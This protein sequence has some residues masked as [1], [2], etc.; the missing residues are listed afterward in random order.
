MQHSSRPM[1]AALRNKAAVGSCVL[2]VMLTAVI[3]LLSSQA[4]ARSIDLVDTGKHFEAV[5]HS[6]AYPGL[7]LKRTAP[8]PNAFASQSLWGWD[9]EMEM[10][11]SGTNHGYFFPTNTAL[12]NYHPH[13]GPSVWFNINQTATSPGEGKYSY[14]HCP[15]ATSQTCDLVNRQDDTRIT[16]SALTTHT[17]T[18]LNTW[19][20]IRSKQFRDGTTIFYDFDSNAKCSHLTIRHGPSGQGYRVL[21]RQLYDSGSGVAYCAPETVTFNGDV[22]TYAWTVVRFGTGAHDIAGPRLDSVTYPDGTK[23]N[24]EYSFVYRPLTLQQRQQSTDPRDHIF[25]TKVTDEEGKVYQTVG[26]DTSRRP[27]SAHYGSSAEQHDKISVTYNSTGTQRT[28][29]DADGIS[30]TFNY[31]KVAGA[32]RLTGVSGP[33]CEWCPE[34]YQSIT[35][36]SHGK[37]TRLVDHRGTVTTITY[38]GAED[39]LRRERQRVVGDGMPE[40]TTVTTT[41]HPTFNLPTQVVTSNA[42]GTFTEKTAYDHKGRTTEQEFIQ[43]IAL[44]NGSNRTV[45]RKIT[46]SYTDWPNG[47][48]QTVVVTGP[49]ANNVTTTQFDTAG[50]LLSTSNALNQTTHILEHD[51]HGRPTRIRASNGVE[52]LRTYDKRGRLLSESI[53][54]VEQRFTYYANGLLKTKTTPGVA[55]AVLTYTYDDA[56]RLTGIRNHLGE[57]VVYAYDSLGRRT[58]TDVLNAWGSRVAIEQTQ[59][60][61]GG[62]TV[63]SYVG[64]QSG[65]STQANMDAG[66]LPS[67]LVDLPRHWTFTHDS[68]GRQIRSREQQG[69][70]VERQFDVAG[71]LKSI[72]HTG[73]GASGEVQNLLFDYAADAKGDV[74]G[75]STSTTGIDTLEH[76][77]AGNVV[78][79]SNSLGGP[80]WTTEY[81]ALNR[82]FRSRILHPSTGAVLGTVN[83]QYD[84]AHNG[85]VAPHGQLTEVSGTYGTVRFEY[86]RKGF[87]TRKTQTRP[88]TSTPTTDAYEYDAAGRLTMMTYPSGRQVLYSL[89]SVGRPQA[90]LTRST[91]S[92]EWILV[93]SGISYTAT[94]MVSR[95]IPVAGGSPPQGIYQNVYYDH[96]GRVT[97]YH[98]GERTIDVT[99]HPDGRV[100]GL[101]SQFVGELA[102]YSYDRLGRIASASGHFGVGQSRTLTYSFNNM[103]NLRSMTDAG[104]STS[105]SYAPGSSRL[106]SVGG[107]A[108]SYV[109]RGLVSRDGINDFG[110]D[111]RGHLTTAQT[112][113]GLA[114]YKYDYEGKRTEKRS[115]DDAHTLFHYDAGGRLIAENLALP[116]G[117]SWIREYVWLGPRPLM[118]IVRPGQGGS[119]LRYNIHVDHTDTP[120]RVTAPDRSTV[121][122]WLRD[123]FGAAV[124]HVAPPFNLPAYAFNLRMPGQY[125]DAETGYHYNWKR[126]YD[127]RTGRYLQPDPLGEPAGA[128]L[129]TYAHGDPVRFT[130]PLGLAPMNLGTMTVYGTP[131]N[132]NVGSLG[133]TGGGYSGGGGFGYRP[134]P[135]APLKTQSLACG[136][137]DA[138]GDYLNQMLD[139][140]RDVLSLPQV[141]VVFAPGLGQIGRPIMAVGAKAAA[142]NMGAGILMGTTFNI[143]SDMFAGRTNPSWGAMGS[144]AGTGAFVGYLAPVVPGGPVG[145]AMFRG[146]T[147]FTSS[148]GTQY[149]LSGRADFGVAASTAFAGGLLGNAGPFAKHV[150]WPLATTTDKYLAAVPWAVPGMAL[151]GEAKS[152]AD[153]CKGGS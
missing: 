143:A 71:G 47:Q 134:P 84:T 91:A 75:E 133:V 124:P 25:L 56:R 49:R 104:V 105:L 27:F 30:R 57:R 115:P 24:Y 72:E 35:Y 59:F 14:V 52:T 121:W 69:Y 127:P 29:T 68:Q 70:T 32:L 6:T 149:A 38:Y 34:P 62:Q 39:P 122:S 45:N 13:E 132:Q 97:Q 86:D 41:W 78:A 131:G 114:D 3:G 36:N 64:G 112:P 22:V 107:R 100:S 54:G 106:T 81:D 128:A 11:R 19:Y 99:Y 66:F 48:T 117:T 110:Y 137:R 147:W 90:V 148:A 76:D 119:E 21:R 61:S 20:R 33:P 118:F 88:G 83:L 93:A 153:G 74:W 102:S 58:L 145:Q 146:A 26:Y 53:D 10:G 55:S 17:T 116:N 152:R 120:V 4:H 135:R 129:Y 130:D 85:G 108:Y 16:F 139:L 111:K 95:I 92:Q 113:S 125:F 79:G 8:K 46:T 23:T 12:V 151:V 18:K 1:A 43:T 77:A 101:N 87:M 65:T 150:G 109:G 9:F 123:P 89:D 42:N 37:Q 44:P 136:E 126:Y 80:R 63:T 5:D 141:Q 144:S 50:R 51:S 103:G 67:G 73:S 31:A 40:K 7:A 94:N 98:D 96:S 138:D 140:A 142:S 15:T 28:V 82:P 2:A 60:S